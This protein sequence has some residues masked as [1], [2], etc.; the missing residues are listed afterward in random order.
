[1]HL[2]AYPY[3]IGGADRQGSMLYKSACTVHQC[4]M[5]GPKVFHKY[6]A[7]RRLNNM[8]SSVEIIFPKEN[9]AVTKEDT[10]SSY[11]NRKTPLGN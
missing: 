10:C 7:K 9:A 11:R 2:W 6:T 5:K 3:W 4:Q 8:Q 1:M